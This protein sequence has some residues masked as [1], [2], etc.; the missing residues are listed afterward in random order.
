[1]PLAIFV[2][3]N[4]SLVLYTRIPAMFLSLYLGID[5]CEFKGNMNIIYTIKYPIMNQYGLRSI[6]WIGCWVRH[7]SPISATSSILAN[8][9]NL[10]SSLV[11]APLSHHISR[12]SLT[13][14]IQITTAVNSH[15]ICRA[16]CYTAFSLFLRFKYFIQAHYRGL[17]LRLG[18]VKWEVTLR[19]RQGP[20]ITLTFPSYHSL[21]RRRL[22]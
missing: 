16:W 1:M 17:P 12:R 3:L 9:R 2:R 20:G 22:C 8:P 4:C 19:G 11:R 18:G 6:W 7:Y 13:T 5:L 21:T 14:S 10:I 15:C